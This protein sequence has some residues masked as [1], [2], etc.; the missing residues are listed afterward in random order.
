[1]VPRSPDRTIIGGMTDSCSS[2]INLVLSA[3]ERA[4]FTIEE[5]TKGFELIR[6]DTV[7]SFESCENVT[8]LE[9]AALAASVTYFVIFSIE[10]KEK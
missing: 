9:T 4:T 7:D 8:F 2:K 6:R 3:S 1:M 5:H 10:F